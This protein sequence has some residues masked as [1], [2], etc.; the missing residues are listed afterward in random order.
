MAAGVS[1]GGTFSNE[2]REAQEAGSPLWSTNKLPRSW[3]HFGAQ[4]Y[5]GDPFCR[6]LVF[7]KRIF[8]ASFNRAGECLYFSTGA[9]VRYVGRQEQRVSQYAH[10][11]W[12]VR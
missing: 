3:D 10:R 11:A 7:W 4:N 12:L 2:L 1:M 8:S 6:F 5:R 9:S